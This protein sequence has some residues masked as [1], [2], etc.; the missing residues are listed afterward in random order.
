MFIGDFFMLLTMLLMSWTMSEAGAHPDLN[1]AIL[2]EADNLSAEIKFE[3]LTVKIPYNK[4]RQGTKEAPPI[5]RDLIIALIAPL[6]RSW[7]QRKNDTTW[8]TTG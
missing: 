7:R 2:E 5:F 1:A 4:M 8:A 3:D 6:A